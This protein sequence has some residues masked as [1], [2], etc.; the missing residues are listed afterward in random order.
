MQGMIVEFQSRKKGVKG[1]KKVF[2]PNGYCSLSDFY[3]EFTESFNR[4][5]Y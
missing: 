3:S 2:D 5:E 4:R 1:K